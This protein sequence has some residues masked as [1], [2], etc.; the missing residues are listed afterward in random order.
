MM[1]NFYSLSFDLSASFQRACINILTLVK[2]LRKV[3]IKVYIVSIVPAASSCKTEEAA[4]A[5]KGAASRGRDFIPIWIHAG[6]DV[7]LCII[8]Q[9]CYSF[10]AAVVLK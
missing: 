4:K 2:L 5:S 3:T 7:N 10:A 1:I 8:N 9:S 6:H